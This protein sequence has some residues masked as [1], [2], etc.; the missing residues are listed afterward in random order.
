[1]PSSSSFLRSLAVSCAIFGALGCLSFATAQSGRRATKSQPPVA[2]PTPEPIPTP[3]VPSDAIK[4]LFRLVVG[5][6]QYDSFSNV[7]LNTFK[8]VMRNCSQRLEDPAWIK[9]DVEQAPMSRGA[10]QK[11]AKTEKDSYVVWLRLNEDNM[12]STPNRNYIEYTVFSPGTAKVLISGATYP[13]ISR[14]IVP[15]PTSGINGD[16]KLNQA[17]RD[18]AD[19][20]IAKF[21]GRIPQ[22][23][24]PQAYSA[25]RSN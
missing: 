17:A 23:D 25:S 12:G 8:S 24:D 9:V 16:D 6:E 13:R 11:R 15:V 21:R 20:I 18:A 5:M 14:T 3:S 7:S 19:K 2:V 10:A 22:S 4:P 1:M